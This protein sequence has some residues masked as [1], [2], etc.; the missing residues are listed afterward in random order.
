M[1][2]INRI[3]GLTVEKIDGKRAVKYQGADCPLINKHAVLCEQDTS[4]N[5]DVLDSW[6][7]YKTPVG[8]VERH[9]WSRSASLERTGTDWRI[10]PIEEIAAAQ[11]RFEAASVEMAAARQAL[12]MVAGAAVPA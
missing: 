9:Y 2:E 8:V 7:T 4:Y 10:V 12:E 1:K 5:G 3:N 11:K 6:E